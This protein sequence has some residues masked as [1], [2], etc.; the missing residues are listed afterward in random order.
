MRGE[1]RAPQ[2]APVSIVAQVDEI[3]QEMLDE[4][5]FVGRGIRLAERPDQGMVVY[6]GLEAYQAIE[7]VPDEEIRKLIRSAVARW[8]ARSGGANRVALYTRGK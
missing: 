3:L 1:L 8:E 2:T 6:V 5:G 7:E 4:S